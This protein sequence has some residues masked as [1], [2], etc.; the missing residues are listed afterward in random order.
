MAFVSAGDVLKL[1]QVAFKL[2]EY[3]F[4]KC[5][6]AGKSPIIDCGVQS[7]FTTFTTKT[8]VVLSV[9]CKLAETSLYSQKNNMPIL[10]P[11]SIIFP[12]ILKN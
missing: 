6:N 3:G 9:Q 5:K 1:G 12:A 11:I 4:S 2:W 8:S 7:W 10:A